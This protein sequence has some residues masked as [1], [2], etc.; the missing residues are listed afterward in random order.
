MDTRRHLRT[1]IQTGVEKIMHILIAA[2]LGLIGILFVA[3]E[4]FGA[5]FTVIEFFV[6]AV[7]FILSFGALLFVAIVVLIIF[8]IYFA[9]SQSDPSLA[10]AFLVTSLGGIVAFAIFGLTAYNKK[11]NGINKMNHVRYN[12]EQLSDEELLNLIKNN[13]VEEF[14]RIGYMAAFTDRHAPN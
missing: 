9:L 3:L 13:S 5:I 7:T 1:D 8:G 11:D 12:S 4:F 14:E 2:V 6:G 10:N